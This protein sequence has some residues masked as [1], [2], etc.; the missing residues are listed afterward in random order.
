[1]RKVEWEEGVR[2][3]EWEEGCENFPLR[4]LVTILEYI[5]LIVF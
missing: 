2:K 3:V 5:Y 1:M 4:R